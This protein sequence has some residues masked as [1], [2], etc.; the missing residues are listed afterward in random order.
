MNAVLHFAPVGVSVAKLNICS[1]IAEEEAGN[2]SSEYVWHTDAHHDQHL[3]RTAKD[4]ATQK[5]TV[6]QKQSIFFFPACIDCIMC[7]KDELSSM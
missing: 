6:Y 2:R 5:A 3:N 7:K 4:T 1:V